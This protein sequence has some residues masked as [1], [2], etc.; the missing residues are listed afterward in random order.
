RRRQRHLAD[1]LTA[2]QEQLELRPRQRQRRRVVAAP[3][4]REPTSR[5]PFDVQRHPGA[6]ELQHLRGRPPPI[7]EQV[8]RPRQRILAER[9]LH[10]RA[11]ALEAL[12]QVDRLSIREHRHTTLRPDHASLRTSSATSATVRPS[13]RTPPA[14][15]T[16]SARRSP[17]SPST[18]T[19]TTS[20][21]STST[22]RDHARNSTTAT[23]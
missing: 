10:E 7:R 15:T 23:P 22:P 11:Q 6:I 5:E 14:S 1:E 8:Q 18:C 16:T 21:A 4:R 13:T 17:V 3:Q 20:G 19:G 2:L 12:A 9:L